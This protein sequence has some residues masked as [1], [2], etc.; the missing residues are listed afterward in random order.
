MMPLTLHG[1]DH[2]HYQSLSVDTE[3]NPQWDQG[4]SIIITIT[5]FLDFSQL[6]LSGVCR[7]RNPEKWWC[8]F[9]INCA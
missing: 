5:Y 4:K 3:N 6:N 2:F 1:P 7:Y 9:N 8:V